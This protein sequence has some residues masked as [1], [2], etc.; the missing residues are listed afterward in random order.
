MASTEFINSFLVIFAN[1]DKVCGGSKTRARCLSINTNVQHQLSRTVHELELKFQEYLP[2]EFDSLGQQNT[3]RF[4]DY[5][6]LCNLYM[7]EFQPKK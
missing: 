1:W 6:P 7:A 3:I 2:L 4:V 5:Y